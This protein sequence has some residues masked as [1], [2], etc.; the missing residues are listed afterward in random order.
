MATLSPTFGNVREATRLY[1]RDFRQFNALIDDEETPDSIMD[2][3]I[4]LTVD[5]FNTTPPN[6]GFDI[7]NFPSKYLLLIGTVIQVLRS[8]GILQSRN[9]LNY[10]D[11][12]ITVSTSDKAPEYQA[13]IDRMQREYEDKKKRLKRSLNAEA[14]YGGIFSEYSYVNYA[15]GFIGFLGLDSFE[16]LRRGF[17][18]P[19]LT[20][21]FNA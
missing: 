7:V 15:G 12:G 18:S 9:R 5:D 10:S 2:L 14:A 21:G 16:V 19:A 4:S 11:G 20:G 3:C 6:T 17:A 13:W 8:A 1:M